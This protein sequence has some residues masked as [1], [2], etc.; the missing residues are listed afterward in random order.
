[1]FIS[2]PVSRAVNSLP[3]S[4]SSDATASQS[5]FF[6][7]SLQSMLEGARVHSID[8]SFPSSPLLSVSLATA[9]VAILLHFLCESVPRPVSPSPVPYPLNSRSL[10]SL[11]QRAA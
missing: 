2:W 5:L 11:A 3:L 6:A 10:F 7:F 1:M 9:A 8:S 4:I